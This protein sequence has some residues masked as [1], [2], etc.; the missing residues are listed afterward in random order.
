MK[1]TVSDKIAIELRNFLCK[2]VSELPSPILC[3][4]S[5]GVDSHSILFAC[6]ETG[7]PVTA[8]SFMLDGVMSTDFYL[9]RRSAKQHG[10]DFIPVIIPKDIDTVVSDVKELIRLGCR[11]KSDIECCFPFKYVAPYTVDFPTLV[12]GHRADVQFGI[13]KNAAMQ[14]CQ[15]DVGI[16][17]AYREKNVGKSCV[18]IKVI[19]KMLDEWK[20]TAL[21]PYKD[22][23]VIKMFRGT[24][25]SDINKP[26]QK[27]PIRST[28]PEQFARTKLKNHTNYQLGDSQ[29][30]KQFERLVDIP[31]I[32]TGGHRSV[33][34]IYN[35]FIRQELSSDV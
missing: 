15:T 12:S 33:V 32:N 22:S 26:K 3:P 9:A 24:K 31:S 29:I 34:G 11:K 16:L 2:Y 5:G 30:S 19:Q 8:M 35:D 17:D 18:Q 10:V 7:T 28:F 13:S 25:W 21:F 20:S 27:Q 6:L 4:L 1:K 23:D 14:G